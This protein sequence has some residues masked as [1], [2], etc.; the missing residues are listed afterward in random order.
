MY[1]LFF[2]INCW[3]IIPFVIQGLIVMD[4][5]ILVEGFGARKRFASVF[6]EVLIFG[7]RIYETRCIPLCFM[8]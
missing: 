3:K 8:L 5:M 2:I 1:F 4:S 7:V 6:F